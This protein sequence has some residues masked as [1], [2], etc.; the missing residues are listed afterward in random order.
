MTTP[1]TLSRVLSIASYRG[2]AKAHLGG[3]VVVLTGRFAPWWMSAS[4]TISIDPYC[5]I[6]QIRSAA[7]PVN[8]SDSGKAKWSKTL[9]PSI[10]RHLYFPSF[11]EAVKGMRKA[12]TLPKRRPAP[13]GWVV[14]VYSHCY[15]GVGRSELERWTPFPKFAKRYQRQAWAKKIAAQLGGQAELVGQPSPTSQ[16]R[17]RS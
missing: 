5:A 12:V 16:I 7:A 17:G 4:L 2:W 1:F 10:M 6:V 3:Q 13:A 15:T 9:P 8:R 14:K 11:P